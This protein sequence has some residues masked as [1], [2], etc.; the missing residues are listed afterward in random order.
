MS[1]FVLQFKKKEGR[2]GGGE[3]RRRGRGRGR[4]PEYLTKLIS[5]GTSYKFFPDPSLFCFLAEE[6]IT[7]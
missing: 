6:L 5:V 3:G 2:R 7:P 1:V 4:S